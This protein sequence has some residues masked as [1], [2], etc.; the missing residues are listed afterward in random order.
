VKVI[1]TAKFALLAKQFTYEYIMTMNI[2]YSICWSQ[3]NISFKQ[4]SPSVV[5]T[6]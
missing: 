3:K 5:R 1:Y 6:N 2:N 4:Y